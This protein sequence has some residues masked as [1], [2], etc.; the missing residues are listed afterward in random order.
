MTTIID[1]FYNAIPEVQAPTPQNSSHRTHV[2]GSS[3]ARAESPFF[4]F[5][6]NLDSWTMYADKILQNRRVSR[7][8][9][10]NYLAT[11]ERCRDIVNEADVADAAAV[12]L[13]N[14]VEL[15]FCAIHTTPI[16]SANNYSASNRSRA[17]KVWLR[18]GAVK[19]W[20]PFA[21]LDY[22]KIGTIKEDEVF[23]ACI[24]PSEYHHAQ[25]VNY[26]YSYQ[27]QYV[28][29]FDWDVLLLLYFGD[30]TEWSGGTWCCL[31]II[32][33]KSHMRKALLGFLERAYKS[34]MSGEAS[35]KPIVPSFA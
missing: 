1:S 22:K 10:H 5:H 23:K 3:T 14:P 27:T 20:E 32:K 9:S 12:Q 16:R 29:F 26:S 19:G 31:T 21:V 30:R 15:A 13:M 6:P 18:Y 7:F 4:A 25:G 33:D 35:L 24:S 28:A 17:D 34:Y 8:L 11:W 2:S